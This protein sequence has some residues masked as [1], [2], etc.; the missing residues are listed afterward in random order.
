M[1]IG[2]CLLG[3]KVENTLTPGSH[4]STFGGN[5]AVCAGALS[6]LNRIDD[7]LLADVRAK[8]DYIVSE[9]SGAEGVKGVSGLG[10]ML[11]VETV[12]PAREVV[13]RG[14]ERGVLALTAKAK[15]RLLPPLTIPM[16]ELK[17]AVALL[18]EAIKPE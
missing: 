12:R 18:K 1:P 4:G 5:P 17:Q 3:E 7:E 6:I 10:L 2:A 14:I 13:E 9:L 16:D 8:S 15:V 11:G